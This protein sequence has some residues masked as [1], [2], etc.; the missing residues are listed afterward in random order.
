MKYVIDIKTIWIAHNNAWNAM[1]KSCRETKKEIDALYMKT[2]DIKLIRD[3]KQ[4]F[5][6]SAVFKSKSDFVMFMM[7]WS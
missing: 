1:N 4:E 6:T 7:E 3:E 2:Y 5:Y